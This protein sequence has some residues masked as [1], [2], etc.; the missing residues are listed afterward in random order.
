MIFN[1]ELDAF[2][3]KIIWLNKFIE[4][5][6]GENTSTSPSDFNSNI[7]LNPDGA[8]W[9]RGKWNYFIKQFLKLSEY[10]GIR[11]SKI[12]I[13]GDT[14]P[15][16]SAAA[17]GIKIVGLHAVE[18]S[19]VHAAPNYK[20]NQKILGKKCTCIGS[21]QHYEICKSSSSCMGSIQS[22]TVF[23]RVRTLLS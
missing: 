2:F 8:E 6:K 20:I 13:S 4:N 10:L 7:I 1:L 11:F 16:H 18:G 3:Y 17:L 12:V 15:L 14:G 22:Q 19:I 23:K 5:I 9:K 21:L